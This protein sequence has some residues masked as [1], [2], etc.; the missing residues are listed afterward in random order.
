MRR[1]LVLSWVVL[2]MMAIARA[3]EPV[4]HPRLLMQVGEEPQV[5][6]ESLFARADS[7][8]VAFSDAV[9][10]EPAVTREFIGRRL[11][12]TS[13]EALK[14][15]F[16]LSYT[17]RV[18]GGEAYARKAIDEMLAVSAFSDWNPAH[19]LD[20]GEMTMAAAI[21]YDWLYEKMTPAERKTVARAIIDKGLK[22]ALNPNDAW[23]YTSEI[24]WN[25]VCNAGMVYGA[26]AVWEEDPD[27]CR[28]MLEKSLESN[29]LAYKAYEGGGYPEGYNYWG[30]GTSFQIM[31]EAAVESAFPERW[32]VAAGHDDKTSD[33]P[34]CDASVM[35]GTSSSAMPNS[36]AS[37]MPGL[38]GHLSHDFL[39]S[40][41]F[42]RFTSTP[43]G[44]CYSF[45][46]SYRKANGQYLQ[47]WMFTRTGD[48]T[49]LY[50]EM[51]IMEDTDYRRLCEERLFP[52]LLISLVKAPG[53]EISPPEK[54][55]Y[56]CGGTTPIFVYRSGWTSR[57]DTYLGIK[58][59]LT[60]SSHSHCDQGSFYFE[61][62]GVAWATD[63][64]MQ[65]YNSL[66]SA[67]VD[68]WDM[69]QDSERWE[70]FR[71]GPFSHNILTVNGHTPKVNHPAAFTRIWAPEG[72]TRQDRVGVEMD[73]TA[74]Y[75]EDLDS[76]KR[77]VYL[78]GSLNI[79]D[80]IQAGDSAC[81]V[82]W[83]M[84]TEAKAALLP[85]PDIN[86]PGY[87]FADHRIMLEAGGHKR[88]LV[89]VLLDE[90]N[91][92][93]PE[94]R[95]SPID[96]DYDGM[97]DDLPEMPDLHAHVW[98]TTYDPAAPDVDGMQYL[99]ETDVANPGTSLVG[100][101]FTLQPHQKV[102][103]HVALL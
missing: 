36:D 33:H 98:P 3:Q 27:F 61:S 30:Y 45:S 25:S 93:F 39:A 24:N 8:I 103:L 38:T 92:G 51:R 58:G 99:H 72:R 79:V 63:L 96:M 59:G 11:L 70:V 82:R 87:P 4:A 55:Y 31:L 29:K 100:Y 102:M 90:W 95:F 56:Q 44:N 86:L 80:L 69:T 9:L 73:L 7:V 52:M 91:G 21:G 49:L 88:T 10:A 43:A 71:I 34:N 97:Y 89:A 67:G 5:P 66:E 35:P 83:A 64:G 65:N 6:P 74:L 76:C 68:L 1:L 28:S 22:P 85:D 32:P 17:Y 94:P 60:M 13:R 47:A 53:F 20:V 42:I 46:D 12:G 14:R 26:L 18:H 77:A 54:H 101:T 75:T 62:D 16:W 19:F 15:I 41:E 48:P 78:Y 57:K 50:P 2:G 23:F 81:T 37:V 84:C 40:S